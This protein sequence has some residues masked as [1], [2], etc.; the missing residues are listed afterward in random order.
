MI[1]KIK[2]FF[3]TTKMCPI[4]LCR[5]AV[6]LERL[7]VALGSSHPQLLL[8][9]QLSIVGLV[10][11]C[12]ES[13]TIGQLEFVGGSDESWSFAGFAFVCTFFDAIFFFILWLGV[14]G[15]WLIIYFTS[16][17]EWVI[18]G[19]FIRPVDSLSNERLIDLLR[20]VR[21]YIYQ[22]KAHLK[23]SHHHPVCTIDGKS[24]WIRRNYCNEICN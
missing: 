22:W 21:F 19:K 5:D 9:H 11:G 7:D 13:S 24:E 1:K 2:H 20:F 10:M 16:M 17:C 18:F 4:V 15:V 14:I 23:M 6:A 3:I 8:L 12:A